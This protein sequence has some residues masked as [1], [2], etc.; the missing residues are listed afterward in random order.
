MKI[1]LE[2]DTSEEENRRLAFRIATQDRVKMK[3]AGENV[4]IL[5]ISETG[6]AFATEAVLTGELTDAE[7][8]FYL[9]ER[10]FKFTPQL[11]VTFC[12]KGRCGAKF[13]QLSERAHVILS[14]LVVLLQKEQIRAS[15]TLAEEQI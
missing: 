14:E 9:G 3:L 13:G 11:E 1:P 12:G 4:E 2:F 5:D 6:I 8:F 15:Q 7:L 10:K